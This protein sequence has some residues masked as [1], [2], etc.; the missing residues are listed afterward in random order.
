M[1][2]IQK[3]DFVQDYVRD[4]DDCVIDKTMITLFRDSVILR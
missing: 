3:F 4:T 2:E 1:L